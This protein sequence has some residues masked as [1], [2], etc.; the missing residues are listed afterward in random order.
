MLSMMESFNLLEMGKDSKGEKT[1]Y[2]LAGH[3]FIEN[4]LKINEILKNYK[5]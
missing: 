1:L 2:L 4:A 5:T 3:D